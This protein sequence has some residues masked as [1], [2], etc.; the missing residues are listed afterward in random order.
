MRPLPIPALSWLVLA[1]VLALGPRTASAS[2]PDASHSFRTGG[3]S[4][5]PDHGRELA[6]ELRADTT[7]IVDQV[8]DVTMTLHRNG[9]ALRIPYYANRTLGAGYS[10]V[11]RAILVINGTLRNADVYFQAAEQAGQMSGGA[12]ATTFIIAPQ[13][14]TEEDVASHHLSNEH[15][16]WTYMGWRKGDQSLSTVQHPRPWMV[17]SFAVADTILERLVASC[18]NLQQVVVAGHSAGGQ[19]TNLYAAGS[20]IPTVVTQ[21][22]GVPMRWVVCNPSCYLYFNDERWIQGTTYEFAVPSAQ[23]IAD[24]PSYNDYKYGLLQPNQYMAVGAD[25]LRA[26]YGRRAVAYLLGELDTNPY[27]YYLD[28]GCEAE[29]Q[30]RYRLERGLVYGGHLTHY[31]G[32]PIWDVQALATVPG[33]GHDETGM[34]TSP[35]GRYYLY[36][37]GTCGSGP[38]SGSWT[39]ATPPLL[40][41]PSAHAV[42]WTDYDGDGDVDIYLPAT[43]DNDL[44]GRNDGSGVFADATPSVLASQ[45]HSM[46]ARWGDYD[47]DGLVDLY[48]LNWQESNR[49]LR[50]LGAGQFE[51]VTS[52]PLGVVGD[53]T[54][55]SWVDYDSDGDLDLYITRTS[56]QSCVLL[57]NN[58]SGGFA[59][60]STSPINVTGNTRSAAWGDYDNDGDPDL[61]I[62]KDG[63]DKLFRNDHGSFVDVTTGPLADNG[64][65]SSASWVDYDND[66]NLDLYIVNR[67]GANHLLRNNGS[68][69][70]SIDGSPINTPGNGRSAIWGDYD[71]DGWIDAYVCNSGGPNR[72]YHNDGAGGFVDATA[73]PLN[74]QSQS[75]AAAWAD[76]NGD[77]AIDLFVALNS[78]ANHLFRNDLLTGRRWLQLSLIGTLSNRSAIGA[79]VRLRANGVWQTRQVGAETGYMAESWPVL[80]FGLGNAS[81]VDSLVIRW[82]SGTVAR[83][84]DLDTNVGLVIHESDV[85]SSTPRETSLPTSGIALRIVPNPFRTGAQVSYRLSSS[86]PV[87]LSILDSQGRMVRRLRAPDDGSASGQILWDGRDEEGRPTPGGVYFG[88]LDGKGESESARLVR[89]R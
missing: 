25:S 9:E 88:R 56:N 58:G 67:T 2:E 55:A 32:A 21:L 49:L 52:G 74:L 51:D 42:S 40:A 5:V 37:Y 15:A 82:P 68:G 48:E 63:P 69:F 30:G 66:G 89:L 8:S 47:N 4:W 35:C 43:D 36:D 72:L 81:R 13:F 73:S 64:S 65:G 85:P 46:A 29:L 86:G 60:V 79:M 41:V 71:N 61:F 16:F 24:C 38:P 11:T 84:W 28:R 20:E 27:D 80:A 78:A 45:H 18:P 57:R 44:L 6:A 75:Y 31:F 59:N 53:C 7:D 26:R 83:F 19:F 33:I 34:F 17:S 62:T 14:L 87:V 50:N 3:V 76:Y 23:T 70:T 10:D 54:D 1:A 39:D 22:Y 77:G 12:D